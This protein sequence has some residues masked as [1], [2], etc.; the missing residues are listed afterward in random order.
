MAFSCL[1]FYWYLI[2]RTLKLKS[3]TGLYLIVTL[4]DYFSYVRKLTGFRY[5]S[6]KFSLTGLSETL[7]DFNEHLGFLCGLTGPPTTLWGC[8]FSN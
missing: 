5:V 6:K 2:M 1:F 8:P 4:R 7:R 3:L